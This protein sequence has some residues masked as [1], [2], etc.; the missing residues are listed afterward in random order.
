MKEYLIEFGYTDE[1]INRK[2]M[3]ALTDPGRFQQKIP[4]DFRQSYIYNQ[5]VR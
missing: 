2:V 5:N 3:G 4:D 1:E